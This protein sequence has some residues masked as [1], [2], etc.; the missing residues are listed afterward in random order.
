[1]GGIYMVGG[2]N[3]KILGIFGFFGALTAKNG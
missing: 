2:Q 1:M 3:F